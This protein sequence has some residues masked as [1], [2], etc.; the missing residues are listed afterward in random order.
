MCLFGSKA[1]LLDLLRIKS[2]LRESEEKEEKSAMQVKE[3]KIM[4]APPVVLAS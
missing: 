1:A 2:S 4:I 3:A